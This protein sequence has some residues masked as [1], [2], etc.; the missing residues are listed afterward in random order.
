MP[1]WTSQ[2]I[3]LAAAASSLVAHTIGFGAIVA[4]QAWDA[5]KPPEPVRVRI[6]EKPP[7]PKVE[8]PIPP[9]PAEPPKPK[10]KPKE[11][12]PVA[13]ERQKP[14]E[15]PK[16]EVK[17]IQG[18][19]KNSLDPT[20]TSAVAAPIGNTLMTKDTG[21]R[22][23]DAEALAA[24]MTADA[25]LIRG[26]ITIPQYTDAALDANFEG[27][28]IVDVFVDEKGDVKEAELRKKVGYG[29]DERIL[30]AAN[31]AKFVP[32]KNKIGTAI[33]GWTELKFNLQIP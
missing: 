21:E 30:L 28:V 14:K 22:V 33:S 11:P 5:N 31:A 26:S 29:M 32:R 2:Q 8:E 25:Q 9:K 7:E 18:L 17:P 19:D 1:R 10:P 4:K 24:D 16:E 3:W 12:P 27:Y 20:G 6:V 13:S 23:T 15:P